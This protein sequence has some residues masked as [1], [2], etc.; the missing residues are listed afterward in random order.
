MR[1]LKV[2]TLGLAQRSGHWPIC[3]EIF[4]LD[5]GRKQR[6]QSKPSKFQRIVEIMN[7][8]NCD[9]RISKLV[10]VINAFPEIQTL[11]SCGGHKKPKVTHSQVPANEFYVDFCFKSRY[12]TKEA[13][14]SL[15]EI[16]RSISESVIYEWARV[17][18]GGVKIEICKEES[19][20]LYFRLHGRNVDPNSIADAISERLSENFKT[21]KIEAPFDNETFPKVK[22]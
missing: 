21:L 15:N 18:S 22:K 6:I 14:Q 3:V 4:R 11:M 12:P 8:K 5:G 13:W 20:H 19:H 17:S 10:E 16:G 7:S 9:Q 1:C 2:S